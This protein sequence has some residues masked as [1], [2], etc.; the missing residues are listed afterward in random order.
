MPIPCSDASTVL[1]LS[2]QAHLFAGK[3]HA[4]L[5]PLIRP[6]S[7]TTREKHAWKLAAFYYRVASSFTLTLNRA[8][9][10]ICPIAPASRLAAPPNQ[11]ALT[12]LLART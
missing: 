4:G 5:S 8:A 7:S 1:L 6:N 10:V 9:I 12:P 11:Q 2:P 3:T